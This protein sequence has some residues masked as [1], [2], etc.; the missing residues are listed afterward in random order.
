VM[1]AFQR[2]VAVLGV[3]APAGSATSASNWAQPRGVE[4]T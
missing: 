3:R 4:I 1:R 2:V